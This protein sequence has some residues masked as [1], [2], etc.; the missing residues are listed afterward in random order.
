MKSLDWDIY[1]CF[2]SVA[3]TGGLTG[4]AQA[5]GSSPATVGRRMLELEERTGRSLFLRSQTGYQ[6]T[7]DGELLFEQLQEMEAAARRVESWRREGAATS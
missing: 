2:M 4:A 1:R 3:R 5:L 6:L 7:G